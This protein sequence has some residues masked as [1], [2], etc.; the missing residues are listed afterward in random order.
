[1]GNNEDYLDSLLNNVTKKLSEFD[2][3]FEQKKETAD[4][5]MT[6]RNLPPKTM[7][8]LETVRENQFLRDFENELKQENVDDFLA[9]FEA[10]LEDDEL[11]YKRTHASGMPQTP[12]VSGLDTPGSAP[13][14]EPDPLSDPE[15]FAKA[16]D[17]LSED[18]MVDTFDDLGDFVELPPEEEPAGIPDIPAAA[19]AGTAGEAAPP[20]GMEDLESLFDDAD[21][22]PLDGDEPVDFGLGGAG[23]MDF[24]LGDAAAGFGLGDDKPADS[25]AGFGTGGDED[26]ILPEDGDLDDTNIMD[27]LNSLPEDEALSD[28]G[29]MLEADE[30]SISLEDISAEPE[31]LFHAADVAGSRKAPEEV[32]KPKKQGFFAKL[33][34]LLF[35]EDEPEEAAPAVIEGADDL[36][37]ISDENMEILKAMNGDKLTEPAN[38]KGKK[39]KEKKKKEK[40]EKQPK[41][42]KEKK[43]REKKP[44]KE[45]P[46]KERGPKEK[47]LPKAPVMLIWI[48][49]LSVFALIFV[50]N[51]LLSYENSIS[52][53]ETSF[54]RGHYVASYNQLA[55]MKIRGSD[56]ELYNKAKLLAG[57]Q[58]ELDAYYSMMEVR[59][60][61]LA[62]DC[63]VRGLGRAEL[64]RDEAVLLG[65]EIQLDTVVD[66][67]AMQ[68]QDQFNVS[69]SQAG[70]LYAL[71][72]RDDYSLALDA[73][74]YGLGLK[75]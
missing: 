5:Y 58:T 11:E 25:A 16:A 26:I 33:M 30:Q 44:K 69:E 63:L 20:P 46:K 57:V 15:L 52:E 59:K 35:G 75:H 66:E 55:G 13:V 53:A 68:L 51:N 39:K 48:F 47:P 17:D 21:E 29:K 3:D 54:D 64:H 65:I 22:L 31:N 45:K 9:A 71:D 18:L 19:S 6:K 38:K 7:K 41:E 4:A 14:G 23:T 36:E 28:I 12:P 34:D 60:F 70:E 27:L 72:Q 40:K 73:V 1:M 8:A 42:K 24:G 32:Q 67:I 74:L 50:G 43:P 61:D 10:E 62:L 49:A 2:E 37:N 56:E